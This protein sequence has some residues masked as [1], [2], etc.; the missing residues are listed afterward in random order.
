MIWPRGMLTKGRGQREKWSTE[1]K[2]GKGLQH[3][4]SNIEMAWKSSGRE[5]TSFSTVSTDI[6]TWGFFLFVLVGF[7]FYTKRDLIEHT[8]DKLTSSLWNRNGIAVKCLHIVN[9]WYFPMLIIL[10][11]IEISS[12]SCFFITTWQT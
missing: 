1:D 12:I 2:H 6:F 9:Y 11:K 4:V 5:R 10:R 7:F 8:E 3:L